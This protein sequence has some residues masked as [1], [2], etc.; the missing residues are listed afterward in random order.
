MNELTALLGV[1]ESWHEEGIGD[2]FKAGGYDLI[3]EAYLQ[4]KAAPTPLIL[5][6]VNQEDLQDSFGTICAPHMG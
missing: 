4:Y 6:A 1:L 3:M 2:D 5:E